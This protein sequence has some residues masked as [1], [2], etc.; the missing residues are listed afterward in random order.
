MS[1]D[2]DGIDEGA[3]SRLERLL[4]I[5]EENERRCYETDVVDSYEG[6]RDSYRVMTRISLLTSYLSFAVIFS[7]FII[8]LLRDE[9]RSFITT[10][11]GFVRE[12]FPYFVD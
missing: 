4:L 9:P 1:D 10:V 6:L 8:Y 5:G 3:N 2:S 12:V 11:H 7:T